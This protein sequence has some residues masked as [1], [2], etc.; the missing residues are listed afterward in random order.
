MYNIFI[1]F[2]RKGKKRRKREKGREIVKGTE[3]LEKEKNREV[4]EAKKY[5]HKRKTK[6]SLIIL[7]LGRISSSF[8]YSNICL[9]Y[10]V[11]TIYI[12]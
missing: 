12:N 6:L 7:G 8:L 2:S 1:S 3:G 4:W 9:N 10:V 5:I 11:S